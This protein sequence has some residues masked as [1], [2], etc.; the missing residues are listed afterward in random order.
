MA[1][2][3]IRATEPHQ[4]VV[5]FSTQAQGSMCPCLGSPVALILQTQSQQVSLSL[6]EGKEVSCTGGTVTTL[7]LSSKWGTFLTFHRLT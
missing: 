4:L 6:S 1:F 2:G 5:A 7:D 3:T